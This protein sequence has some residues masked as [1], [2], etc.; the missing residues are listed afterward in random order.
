M[1]FRFDRVTV[2]SVLLTICLVILMSLDMKWAATW[3]TRAVWV[4]DKVMRLNY[5]ASIAFT[6]LALE[7]IV[8]IVIWTSYQKRVRWSW[9]VMLVFVCVYFLP[10]R[11]LD[12]FLGIRSAGWSWWPRA[13]REAMEG[14]QLAVSAF[15]EVAIFAVMVIAL[16]VPVG[17]FFSNR[18]LCPRTQKS[19]AD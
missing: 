10:V 12:L 4:T 8:L 14:H 6:S 17:A 13:V 9:F 18:D 11:L 2:S 16:I 19:N 5:E 15:S 7:I 1:R 3:P